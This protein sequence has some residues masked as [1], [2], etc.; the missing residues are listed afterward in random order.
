MLPLMGSRSIRIAFAAATAP[1]RRVLISGRRTVKLAWFVPGVVAQGPPPMGGA[2]PVPVVPP[3][4]P[5]VVVVTPL[6]PPPLPTVE[7]PA[8]VEV[9]ADPVAPE[10]T[11]VVSDVVAFFALSEV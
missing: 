11:V 7:P 2:P 4:A 8:P 10:P 3:P 6:E 5:V 9:V 1:R